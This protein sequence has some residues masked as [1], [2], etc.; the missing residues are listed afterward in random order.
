M[1]E[2]QKGLD[3]KNVTSDVRAKSLKTPKYDDQMTE[4]KAYTKKDLVLF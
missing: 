1:Q 4:P 3:R 2:I